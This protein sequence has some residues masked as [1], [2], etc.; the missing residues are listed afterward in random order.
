[1]L[2]RSE[3]EENSIIDVEQLKNEE[4]NPKIK[5]KKEEEHIIPSSDNHNNI[6]L[7]GQIVNKTVGELGSKLIEKTLKFTSTTAWT[8][9]DGVNYVEYFIVGGGG[10]GGG[11]TA[12]SLSMGNSYFQKSGLYNNPIGAGDLS[13]PSY[14][15]SLPVGTVISATKAG[16][17]GHVQIKYGPGPNDWASDFDQKGRGGVLMN[18][19]EN[20]RVHIPNDAGQKAL[21]ERGFA[22]TSTPAEVKRE[23]TNPNP[24]G[25][26]M[27]APSVAPAAQSENIRPAPETP[28]SSEALN[29]PAA[30]ATKVEEQ[31]V[32]VKPAQIGRAHV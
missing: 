9:P 26:A 24:P 4:E 29:A 16:H 3:I 30:V 21:G 13:D 7:D 27:A 31:P 22:V 17:A 28:R 1:M 20:F 5:N 10:S 18:G 8:V 15:A 12:G 25:A 6:A 32:V 11:E 19:Y 23:A 2:F 14:R